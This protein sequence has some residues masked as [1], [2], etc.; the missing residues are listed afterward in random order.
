MTSLF[1]PLTLRGLTVRNRVFLP[2]MCT[3]QVEA[4]DG[5]PTDWHLVHYG[6]RAAGGFGLIIAEAAG[7]LPEGRITPGCTGFWNDAQAEAW[8]RIARFA[9]SQGAAFGIQ[10]QHSGRKGSV[11]RD[12]PGQPS[13]SVPL[14]EGG[15][16]TVGPTDEAFPGL[17]APRVATLADI[18]AIKQAFVDAAVRADHAGLDTIQ[19]HAAHGYLLFQFLSPLCNKRTDEYG[20]DFAGRTRLLLETVAAVREVW[21]DSK[22][23]M[24]RISA[25]EWVDDGWSAEDSIELAK[26]L[27]GL[28]VDM[29]DVSSGGN[30][31]TKIPSYPGYQ[32]PLAREVAKGGV[33]VSAVGQILD[34][35]QAQEILDDGV[36]AA[37][38]IGRAA[39]R[40]PGWPVRAGHELGIDYQQLPYSPSYVRGRF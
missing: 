26:L 3:Y 22:P 19:L 21:P 10:L 15:W 29:I 18:A 11:Y 39:L 20:G 12:L 40:D 16:E 38:S 7:V 32:V 1:D 4:G 2:P 5:V 17:A 25:S 36:I 28:G 14:A 37:V 31:I 9:H 6:A 34:G 8:A 13:G 24:V 30:I 23:L 35:P 33:P 27:G